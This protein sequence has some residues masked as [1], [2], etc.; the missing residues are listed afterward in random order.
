MQIWNSERMQTI[1]QAVLNNDLSKVCNF[2]YCPYAISSKYINLEAAKTDDDNFNFIIDQIIAGKTE[3]ESPPY[4]FTVSSSGRCNLKCVMCQAEQ[5]YV[6]N[7]D[8]LDEKIFTET[9]PEI[10]PGLSRLYLMGNGEV[11]FNAHSRKFLQNLDPEK[12][13]LLKIDLLTNGT[14]FTPKLWETISHNKFDNIVVS[15]DAA[16]KET[17]QYIRKNGNWDT[18]RRNLDLIGE[19]RAKNVFTRFSICFCVMKSNYKEMKQFVE[20]GK[21]IGCDNTE[22]TKIFGNVIEENINMTAN[23][24]IFAEIAS[25]L[26]DPIFQQNGVNTLMIDEYR[27]YSGKETNVVD[28]MVTMGKELSMYLPSKAMNM[29]SK[30]HSFHKLMENIAKLKKAII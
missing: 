7:D 25:I 12:Y 11:F 23:K 14:L 18:L 16:T 27:N 26:E 1:R 4:M 20:L 10:L 13:P 3:M 6:R 29:L 21:T 15:I 2:N 19:L 28:R 8:M 24:K 9:L 30:K 22:F 17:Y 5:K